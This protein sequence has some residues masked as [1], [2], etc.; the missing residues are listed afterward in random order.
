MRLNKSDA[1][2]ETQA[3]CSRIR[4][5]TAVHGVYKRLLLFLRFERLKMVGRDA[6]SGI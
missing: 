4:I 6:R 5:A 3:P 1:S 2:C